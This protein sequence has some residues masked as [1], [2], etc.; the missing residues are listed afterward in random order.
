MIPIKAEAK[1]K[2]T[3]LVVDSSATGQTVF[4]E[5]QDCI[6]LNNERRLLE[7]RER[8]EIVRILELITNEIRERR[9]SIENNQRLLSD[10]DVVRACARLA[11]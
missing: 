6:E 8:R 3:G 2:L 1:R 4:V 10:F 11:L 5:P 9:S 7:G